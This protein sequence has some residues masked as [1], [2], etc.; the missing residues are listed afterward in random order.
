MNT[1]GSTSK[2]GA[3]IT[4]IIDGIKSKRVLHELLVNTFVD[5]L[6]DMQFKAWFN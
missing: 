5:D 6:W 1:S 2:Q 3:L 4:C